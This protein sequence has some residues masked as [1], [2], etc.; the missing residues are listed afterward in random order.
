MLGKTYTFLHSG[1]NEQLIVGAVF[2]LVFD[3]I[4]K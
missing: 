1:N 3:T 4:V 2:G